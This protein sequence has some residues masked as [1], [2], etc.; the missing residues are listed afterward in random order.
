MTAQAHEILILDGKKESMAFRPSLPEND[1]RIILLKDDEIEPHNSFTFSTSC[2]R[3]YI[4][5][6]EIKDNIFYL[7][8]LEGRFKLKNKSAIF[9]DWFTGT[10]RITQGRLLNY[11][12][13]GYASVYEY[14]IHIKV[15]NGE[16]IKFKK[17]D[18]RNKDFSMRN[19]EMENL[20]GLE[21]KFDGDDDF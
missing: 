19:L 7:V 2:W 1:A 11:V 17:I 3:G 18:N 20:P 12:H 14:E 10:L 4:G 5:T 9:A 16:I 8:N 6:W 21:N 15:E 13:M